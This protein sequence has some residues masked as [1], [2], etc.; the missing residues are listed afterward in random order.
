MRPEITIEVRH[1]IKQVLNTPE[2]GAEFLGIS[3]QALLIAMRK[4]IVPVVGN[5]DMGSN[6]VKYVSRAALIELAHDE[7]RLNRLMKCVYAANKKKNEHAKKGKG[8]KISEAEDSG[9]ASVTLK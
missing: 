3:V 5:P 1:E 9:T 4:G 8:E 6:C 7:E 2:V